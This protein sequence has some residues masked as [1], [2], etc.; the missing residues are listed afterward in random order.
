MAKMGRIYNMIENFVLENF[1]HIINGKAIC[2]K[3]HGLSSSVF[4]V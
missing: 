1:F 4:C 3:T 2:K